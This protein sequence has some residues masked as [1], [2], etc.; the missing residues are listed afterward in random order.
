VEKRKKGQT[1]HLKKKI[2]NS[3]KKLKIQEYKKNIN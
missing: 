3:N 2:K 1:N